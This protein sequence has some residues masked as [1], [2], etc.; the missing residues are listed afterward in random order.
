MFTTLLDSWTN[1][2]ELEELPALQYACRSTLLLQ[3][4]HLD[5]C[6]YFNPDR[7][8][9]TIGKDIVYN[10]V[11]VFA[12][13]LTYL[14]TVHG[15]SKVQDIFSTC[16]QRQALDWFT[17]EL[18]DLERHVFIVMSIKEI[19]KQLTFRFKEESH[20]ALHA[21]HTEQYTMS[22]IHTG[23]PIWAYVQ[24]MCCYAQAADLDSVYA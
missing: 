4:L 14:A 2:P 8:P 5:K 23:K 6:S 20:K 15:N 11:Y 18:S 3:Q 17:S 9:G 21:L 22:N 16:L 12:D 24:S 10:N 13:C 7:E 19:C 1:F